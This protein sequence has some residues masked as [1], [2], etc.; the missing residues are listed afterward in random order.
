MCGVEPLRLKRLN[1]V[2]LALADFWQLVDQRRIKFPPLIINTSSHYK[3]MGVQFC[4]DC[5][6]LLDEATSKHIK[7]DICGKL[8]KS[9]SA[10][11]I[12][13]TLAMWP[14]ANVRL[15]PDIVSSQTTTSRSSNFPST[16]RTKLTSTT[17]NLTSKDLENTRRIAKECPKCHA[18]EMTWSEAQLRSADEGS[19]I[20]YRCPDCGHR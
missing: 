7:C 15:P 3:T 5:G 9:L 16:L 1:A 17:Q 10:P 12:H 14:L 11:F 13:C 2:L 6:S 8:C 4:D 20:F 19:T 18:Q